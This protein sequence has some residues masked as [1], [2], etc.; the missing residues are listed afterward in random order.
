MDKLIFETIE[1]V[2]VVKNMYGREIV[3]VFIPKQELVATREAREPW[4]CEQKPGVWGSGLIDDSVDVGLL[5]EIAFAKVTG[6]PISIEPKVVG[7]GG[8]SDFQFRDKTV[9][10]KTRGYASR[11]SHLLVRSITESGNPVP[12]KSDI[13][14]AASVFSMEHPGGQTVDLVGYMPL[15]GLSE[16]EDVPARVGQHRNKEVPYRELEA[17]LELL[18]TS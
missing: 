18:R 8:G 16:R 2:P 11:H 5:G 6:L 3:R 12:L 7:T 15:E 14:V 1:P 13:Y 10:V 9:E 17:I 4:A